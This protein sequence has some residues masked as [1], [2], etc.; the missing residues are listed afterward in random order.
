MP[1]AT[2]STTIS[3]PYRSHSSRTPRTNDASWVSI[4]PAAC[5][6]G[7][8]TTAQTWPSACSRAARISAS[9]S[10]A[11]SARGLPVGEHAGG[12]D[13]PGLEQD[14]AVRRV[15]QLDAADADRADRVAVVALGD[16]QVERPRPAT[17]A[18]GAGLEGHLDRGLD[19]RR[20]VAGVEHPGQPR[21]R[22]GEQPL[23]QL[24]ARLVGEAE[25]GRVVE[26]LELGPDRR[27][28]LRH[29]VPVH[30][31]PQRGDAVEVPVA[32]GVPEVHA[33]GPVDDDRLVRRAR[34]RA[35]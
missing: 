7:S 19:R 27:V 6:S 13:H 30:R 16:V 26:A 3:A 9:T 18:L 1:V 25:E 10:A 12:G 34:P 31:D 15:E 28:D 2:S 33:L 24:D 11:R 14:R 21:G 8:M 35:G 5:T 20:A 23:R 32:V 4:P 17:G 22:G 29:P